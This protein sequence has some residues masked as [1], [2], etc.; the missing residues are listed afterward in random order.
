MG[1]PR[2]SRMLISRFVDDLMQNARIFWFIHEL[3]RS[4][5]GGVCARRSAGAT[6]RAKAAA[7]IQG[8]RYPLA[9]SSAS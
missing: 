4:D 9:M 7:A 3:S 5:N 2:Q 6:K 8:R 1:R